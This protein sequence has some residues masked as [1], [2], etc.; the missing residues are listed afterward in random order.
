MENDKDHNREEA[1]QLNTPD[2]HRD[3]YDAWAE[4]YD[5]TFLEAE[6]YAAPHNLAKI[7][8][9]VIADTHQDYAPIADIGCGTGAIGQELMARGITVP[10]HGFDISKGMMAV[11]D[12]NGGY[13]DFFEADITAPLGSLKTAKGLKNSAI[14]GG[15]GALLSSGTFTLGHLGPDDLFNVFSLMRDGGLIAVSINAL[16]FDKRGFGKSFQAW[17]ESGI[18]SGLKFHN[19]DLYFNP[20]IVEAESTKGIVA[21]FTINHNNS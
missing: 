21:V 20:E 11:A 12:A 13:S 8:A 15:Y 16:H 2:D 14:A 19:I 5:E 6:G 9:E 18:I 3:Y 1:Y 10:L 4:S 7:F 17:Q